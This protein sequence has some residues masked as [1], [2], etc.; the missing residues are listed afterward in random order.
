MGDREWGSK[1]PKG[2]PEE[3][4]F[5][6]KCV[7]SNQKPISAIESSHQAGAK[8]QTTNFND[9]VC[10]A[11]RWA[12]I[13]ES[14]I[15]WQARLAE[16]EELCAK[17]RRGDGRFDVI[18]PASGGKDSRYVAHILKAQFGMNPLTVTWKPHE[19]TSIGWDNMQTMVDA[20]LPNVM[21]SPPGDLQRQ[22][23]RLAFENLGHPFQPFIIGQRAIGPKLALLYDIRLIFYGENNAE[24]GNRIEDNLVPVMD[25][26]LFTCFDFFGDRGADHY[27]S[28]LPI[29][30]L[31]EKLHLSTG[32]LESYRSPSLTEVK[33][34]D[35]EVHYMS[36]YRKWVPQENYYYAVQKTGFKPNDTRK[37][38]SFTRYAGID[39]IM[40]D[41]HYFMQLIKFGMGSCTWDAAQEVRTGKLER[42]EAVV[43]VR[44]YDAEP[45]SQNLPR[46]LDYLKIDESHFWAV[47]NEFR[48]KHLWEE[49]ENGFVLKNQV[50]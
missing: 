13:K 23:S 35:I 37:Q 44:K 39:D 48:S 46:I 47:V 3:V 41:L 33:D 12:E 1:A 20:G 15:D 42:E 32:D 34:A 40:E 11:C 22:L 6:R 43:L 27:V 16:L 25:P 10:D 30:E 24:Y 19:F 17:H 4:L 18:V 29:A 45:P 8:K 38:G 7:I 14:G 26:A 21:F 9:G 28:G 50:T 36:Y 5:C 2:L 31:M 49:S